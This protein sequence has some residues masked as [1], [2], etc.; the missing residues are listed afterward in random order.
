[1]S[2]FLISLLLKLDQKNT[3]MTLI[4]P[5]EQKNYQK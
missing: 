4:I 1:M 5:P 2:N 3:V